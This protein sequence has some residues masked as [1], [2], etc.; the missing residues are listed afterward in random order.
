MLA[1]GKIE[2]DALTFYV[3][4]KGATGDAMTVK[5]RTLQARLLG[6]DQA[7]AVVIVSSAGANRPAIDAFLTAFG[8]VDARAKRLLATA[9]GR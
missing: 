4:G 3:L 6:G 8:P 1:P 9:R 5:L 7:A 2:R